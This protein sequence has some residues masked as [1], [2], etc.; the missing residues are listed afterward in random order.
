MKAPLHDARIVRARN[1][2]YPWFKQIPLSALGKRNALTFAQKR[3]ELDEL[4][5]RDEWARPKVGKAA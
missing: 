4:L 3:A 5:A 2:H 1:G